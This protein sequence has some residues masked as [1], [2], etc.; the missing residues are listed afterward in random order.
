MLITMCF[1]FSMLM[2]V[3]WRAEPLCNEPLNMSYIRAKPL[4][5]HELLIFALLCCF[6]GLMMFWIWFEPPIKG[7]AIAQWVSCFSFLVVLLTRVHSVP[8]F[9]GTFSIWS[10]TGFGKEWTKIKLCF[11]SPKSHAHRQRHYRTSFLFCSACN[12]S[13][14]FMVQRDLEYWRC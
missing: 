9:P 4:Q 2:D 6:C 8:H 14:W 3:I 7:R 13:A 10:V 5:D 1:Q 11:T 12:I